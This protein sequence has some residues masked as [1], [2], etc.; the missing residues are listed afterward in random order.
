MV[1]NNGIDN[2][3]QISK[4]KNIIDEIKKVETDIIFDINFRVIN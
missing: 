4:Y 3:D 1:K 2:T